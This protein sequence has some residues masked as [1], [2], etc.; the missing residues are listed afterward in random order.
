MADKRGT[1]EPGEKQSIFTR[2]RSLIIGEA[3]NP[4]DRSVFHKL[5]LI[6]VFA[7]IGLGADAFSS[8]CYGPEE[9]FRVV[10]NYP[11]LGL[12]VG[13]ATSVTII[14]ISASYCSI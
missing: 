12:F 5:S 9:A 10:L 3:R 13:I 1:S 6:A 14:I 8:S 7:W 2:L 11:F 4:E